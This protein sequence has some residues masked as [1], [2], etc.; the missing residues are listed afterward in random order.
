METTQLS[1]HAI[2]LITV[3]LAYCNIIDNETEETNEQTIETICKILPLLYVKASV[4][5]LAENVLEEETEK[6]VTEYQYEHVR[7]K[8]AGLLGE[9]DLYLAVSEENDTPVMAS[10]SEDLAD[11]YQDIKD[12]VMNT[13]M[14]TPEVRRIALNEC[15]EGFKNYWGQKLLNAL[16]QLHN[17]VYHTE[18]DVDRES[19]SQENRRIKKESFGDFLRDDTNDYSQLL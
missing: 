12:F 2:E 6:F 14:G 3:G 10:I 4:V 19:S 11:V 7:E 15:I 1:S 8:I 13:K 17:I 16:Q 5:K 18:N 9:F